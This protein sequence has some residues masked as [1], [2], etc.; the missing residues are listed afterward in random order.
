MKVC[1]YGAG[2]I[3]GF[4]G[5]RLAT[6]GRCTVSAL[7]RGATL[8]ALQTHCWRLHQ[9]DALLQVAAHA[10][11]EPAALGVQDL[12]VLAVKGPALAEVASRIGPLLGPHTAVL[13][14]MNGVPW[15]FAR[16]APALGEAPLHSVDPGGHIAAAID[17]Q[18][19]IGCVVHASTFT[20]EPG[21]V[22][23]KMGQGLILGE[24]AGGESPRVQALVELLRHAGFDATLSLQIRQDIWYKLWGN[25]TMNPVSAITG[26]PIDQLMADPLVLRFCSDAMREAA[27][28]GARIGCRIE[29]S[30]EDRH[31]ITRK[32]GSFKTSMQ[33]DVEAGRPIELDALVAVVREM[34]QR[35]D[36]ATPNIDALLGLTRLFARMHGLYPLQSSLPT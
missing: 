22:Q 10:S 4:I 12:V 25:M 6:A 16:H 11:D 18:R 21:L 15:W 14:A 20:T 32:L 8:R 23:H 28:I 30:P 5:T 17:V 29:Q 2:A 9:G 31:A 27:A 1:I 26:A 34:A 36:I 19:V 13:P 24:P 7:A 35:L 33:Q 3:G